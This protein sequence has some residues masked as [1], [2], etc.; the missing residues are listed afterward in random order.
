MRM[1]QTS[2]RGGGRESN[3]LCGSIAI[4]VGLATKLRYHPKVGI[5][6]PRPKYLKKN[7]FSEEGAGEDLPAT[8]GRN[9]LHSHQSQAG[10]QGCHSTKRDHTPKRLIMIGSS[11]GGVEA[12]IKVLACFEE[13]SPPVFIVQHTGESFSPGL[14]RVLNEKSPLTVAEAQHGMA[15]EPGMAV[16]GPGASKHLEVRMRGDLP[17][18]SLV[19]APEISGH[20]PSVD[21]LFRSGVPFASAIVAAILTGMGRDGAA[22]LLALKEA[23]ARTFGQDKETS[24][25]YGMPKVA[26]ELKAVQQ[27]LP[28]DQIGPALIAACSEASAA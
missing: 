10:Q 9:G 6:K 28:I 2:G 7:I 23:G 13:I 4:R 12:L 3:H 1:L 18:C 16:I 8:Q 11:T 14:A 20:R 17:V 24:L 19:S 15:V 25:V 27:Q 5:L 21:A 26:A 22:G